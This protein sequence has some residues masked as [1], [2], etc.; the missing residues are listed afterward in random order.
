MSAHT[1]SHTNRKTT[2]TSLDYMA[3][4]YW[5]DFLAAEPIAGGIAYEAQLHE[6]QLDETLESLQRV[7][8]LISQIRRDHNQVKHL[9]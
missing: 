4:G 9:R 1:D 5:Q 6:C 2:K 7:D 8:T 3:E